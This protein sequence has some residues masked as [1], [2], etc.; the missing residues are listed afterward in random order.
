M[1][2]IKIVDYVLVGVLAK[3]AKFDFVML[4]YGENLKKHEHF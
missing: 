4:N 3:Y 2:T 1:I